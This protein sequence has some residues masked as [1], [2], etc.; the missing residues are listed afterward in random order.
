M[1]AIKKKKIKVPRTN[2]LKMI[3]DLGMCQVTIYNALAFR[4]NS[5]DSIRVR[6][7]AMKHY[8]GVM[9][10]ETIFE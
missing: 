5:M 4:S 7:E 8:G 6:E 9:T 1:K 10:Y 2:L 3:E